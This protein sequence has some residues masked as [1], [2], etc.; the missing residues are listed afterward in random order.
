MVPTAVLTLRLLSLS[1]SSV[2]SRAPRFPSCRAYGR[3][4]AR[5]KERS[6]FTG[7]RFLPVEL[8]I[9]G[10]FLEMQN[11]RRHP[12]LLNQSLHFYKI[13]FYARYT[14]GNAKL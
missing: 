11:L 1:Y 14:L 2:I 9:T 5:D 7:V 3:E 10:A 13:G 12:D 4:R 8:A 6:G